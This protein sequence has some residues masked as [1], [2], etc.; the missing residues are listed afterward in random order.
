MKKLINLDCLTCCHYSVYFVF[1]DSQIV[2]AGP[3][4]DSIGTIGKSFF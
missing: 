3:T 2:R 4:L 1:I